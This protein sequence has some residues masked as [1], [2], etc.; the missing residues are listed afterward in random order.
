MKSRKRKTARQRIGRPA[1]KTTTYKSGNVHQWP[2]WLQLLFRRLALD[3]ETRQFCRRHD[4]VLRVDG[5]PISRW[6]VR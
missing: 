1:K 2:K 5:K 6:R 3:L 4:G